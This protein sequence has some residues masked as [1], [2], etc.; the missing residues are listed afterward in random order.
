VSSVDTHHLRV[1][2]ADES[3][4][5]LGM[6]STIV[7]SLGHEVIARAI[8]VNEVADLSHRDHPDVALVGLDQSSAHAL[9]LIERIAKEA[10]C[11]AIVI[12]HEPDPAFL[13]EAA[14]RG[15]FAYVTDQDPGGWQN[16]I[17]IVLHR[18]AEYHSLK[19]AFGRRALIEQAKGI[20]MER[21][22]TDAATA[23]AMLRNQARST[24]RKLIDIAAAVVEGHPLLPGQP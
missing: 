7:A 12:L 17:E 9:E 16:T 23:F 3:E 5:R 24:N 19:G 10:T 6:I 8:A 21:H 4:D 13:Q 2:V 22:S 15:V 18:F 11:P 20:L 1:L 14:R